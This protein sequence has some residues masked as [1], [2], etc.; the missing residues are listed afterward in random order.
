MGAIPNAGPF[1]E[2]SIEN[3]GISKQAKTLYLP[4]LETEDG[5]V[6]IPYRP[7]WGVRIREDWFSGAERQVSE[8]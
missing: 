3:D 1:F 4:R 6:A 5:A 2:L 7:G 8:A